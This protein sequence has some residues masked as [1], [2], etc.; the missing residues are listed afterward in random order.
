GRV[1]TPDK[2]P[3]ANMTV[4]IAGTEYKF[5]DTNAKGE[6][7]FTKLAEGLYNIRIGPLG[8]PPVEGAS[9]VPAGTTGLEIVY[10][11]AEELKLIGTVQ[12][13]ETK[14]PIKDFSV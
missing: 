9:G 12:D 13:I 7:E 5:T 4:Q 1:V 11:E 8:A 10:T 14:K 6:F 3:V 2:Q